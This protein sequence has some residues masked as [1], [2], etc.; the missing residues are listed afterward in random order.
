MKRLTKKQAQ[1]SW[2]VILWCGGLSSALV[3]AYM[4][5]WVMKL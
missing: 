2:F 4:I 5:R 1:W 3:L